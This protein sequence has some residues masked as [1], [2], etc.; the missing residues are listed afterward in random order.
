MPRN[1]DSKSTRPMATRLPNEL[2]DRVQVVAAQY[3]LTP[4]ALIRR[5]VAAYLSD[6]A[7]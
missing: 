7:I 3:D 2:A 1:V 5:C 4:A 6:N